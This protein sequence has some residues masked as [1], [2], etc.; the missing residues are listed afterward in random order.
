M[1]RRTVNA[2]GNPAGEDSTFIGDYRANSSAKGSVF[3]VVGLKTKNTPFRI[4]IE[5]VKFGE[6]FA[7]A[8]ALVRS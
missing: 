8:T 2:N 6:K 1:Q 4:D 5:G 3:T 7:D